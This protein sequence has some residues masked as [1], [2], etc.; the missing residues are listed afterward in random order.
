MVNIELKLCSGGVVRS[1]EGLERALSAISL[2][3]EAR[4]LPAIFCRGEV[5]ER[6]LLSK[7]SLRY[8]D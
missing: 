5:C 3:H 7:T 1:F 6:Y 8:G 4:R 2:G